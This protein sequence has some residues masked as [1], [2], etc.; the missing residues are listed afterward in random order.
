VNWSPEENDAYRGAPHEPPDPDGGSANST[1]QKVVAFCTSRG[2]VEEA[3][4][5]TVYCIP[6]SALGD[7]PADDGRIVALGAVAI[8]SVSRDMYRLPPVHGVC[9]CAE[10]PNAL[11]V[12]FKRRP[13]DD[14]LRALHEL[15]R[16]FGA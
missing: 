10:N 12:V 8:N 14:E 3:G 7:L 4:G 9:C 11:T 2:L 5:E 15:V 6:A 13:K 1:A 16:A